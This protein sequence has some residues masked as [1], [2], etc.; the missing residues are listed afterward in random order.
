[1]P[2]A[3]EDG[4]VQAPPQSKPTAIDPEAIPTFSEA[5]CSIDLKNPAGWMVHL[6]A[7]TPEQLMEKLN[8]FFRATGAD[9]HT[10]VLVQSF[11]PAIWHSM[12]QGH[13]VEQALG[14]EPEDELA[15]D[16][17]DGLASGGARVASSRGGTQSGGRAPRSDAY[18]EWFTKKLEDGAC[19]KCGNTTFWDNRQDIADGKAS[20]RSPQFK[21]KECEQG[22]WEKPPQG[23]GRG[24]P[25]RAD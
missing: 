16:A 14:Y 6:R 25:S 11:S 1:M 22:F 19:P 3:T 4:N 18:P 23:R 8:G 7:N 20:E 5:P 21:C 2:E 17:Y 10:N 9:D 24:R 12:N 15:K 13:P